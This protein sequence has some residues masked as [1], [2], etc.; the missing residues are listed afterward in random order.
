MD[1]Q[2][3]R[4]ESGERKQGVPSLLQQPVTLDVA[5]LPLEIKAPQNGFGKAKG[6]NGSAKANG[7]ATASA[8]AKASL[9]AL[10]NGTAHANVTPLNGVARVRTYEEL[11]GAE[12][13]A[14][15]FRPHRYSAADFAPLHGAVKISVAG[16][17][18]D[19]PL[20]DL[21]Q[22]GVAFVSPDGDLPV[23]VRQRLHA[24]LC[25]DSHEAFRGEVRVGSV[26]KQ[27]GATVVGVSFNDF[28]LDV[29]ELLQLRAV[30]SWKAEGAGPRLQDKAWCL[31]GADR[32]KALVAELRLYFEDAQ[33]QLTSLEQQLPWHVLHGP[34][35][36]A[37]AALISRLR[38]EFVPDTVRLSEEVDAALRE[39]PEGH[40]NPAAKEWS[41][42]H[43]HGFLMQAPVLHRAYHKPFGYPG[44][45]EVMNFI[46]ARGFEGASLFARAVGLAFAQT[47]APA[48]VRSRKDLVKRHLSALLARRA[49]TGAPVRVLSIAAGPAQELEEL[50]DD[51]DEMPH[52]LELVL[53]EQDKNALAHAWRRLK[54]TVEARSSH[55]VRLMFLHD[56]IK[57]LLRDAD[58]FAPFGKFDLI[59]SCG[60]YDYLQHRT[61]VVLTRRLASA[62]APGG[63]LLVAN[64]VDH[65][66]RWLMEHHLDWPLV[67]RTREE[68]M[69]IG[70]QAV[71]GAELRILEEESGVNPFLQVLRS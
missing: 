20:R 66:T 32:F 52:G 38:A 53:F 57:R 22:N 25:F 41:L 49:G 23:R 48:A 7:S 39:L 60:M 62:V 21:S 16:A 54:S 28:L 58:L 12:G 14:V 24:V 8:S 55:G 37:R 6:L 11:D 64:M 27:D 31:S 34:A 61:A 30:R 3:K 68:L 44:D 10:A 45:Y 63:Q 65:P 59:Y 67:Y 26:R 69:E 43:L 42:R 47:R 5:S 35:N 1:S 15:F 9:S 2:A 33:Q 50:F 4:G 70:A 40:D 51:L 36:P 56:S 29:E 18:H 71:P 13:R 17:T 46:Y 19:C